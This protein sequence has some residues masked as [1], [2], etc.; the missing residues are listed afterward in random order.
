MQVSLARQERPCETLSGNFITKKC[1]SL[2]EKERERE[3]SLRESVGW[4]VSSVFWYWS[5]HEVKSFPD[6]ETIKWSTFIKVMCQLSCHLVRFT[7]KALV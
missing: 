6:F 1:V 5:Y 3:C 4:V 2:F 7:V